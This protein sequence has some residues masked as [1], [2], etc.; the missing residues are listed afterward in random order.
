MPATDLPHGTE[1]VLALPVRD[2]P[3]T[4]SDL[5]KCRKFSGL[6]SSIHRDIRSPD[7]AL[8]DKGAL[9]LKRLGFPD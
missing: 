5:V 1:D 6:V 9:A 4:I 7:P 2:I 8:R 3:D